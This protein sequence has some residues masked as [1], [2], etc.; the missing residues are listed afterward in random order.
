MIKYSNILILVLI[1]VVSIKIKNNI[2]IMEKYQNVVT[3]QNV[4]KNGHSSGT[5][6]AIAISNRI[7]KDSELINKINEEIRDRKIDIDN[8]SKEITTKINN[9]ND[10]LK[11][12]DTILTTLKESL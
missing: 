11:K 10:L 4:G 8:I 7:K 2:I 5:Q 3:D 9:T 12:S 6:S 1:I